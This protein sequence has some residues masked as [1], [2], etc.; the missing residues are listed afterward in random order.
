[1]RS[2]KECS[3]Y[4]N[5]ESSS[6]RNSGMLPNRSNDRFDNQKRDQLEIVDARRRPGERCGFL[7]AEEAVQV[8]LFL[9]LDD[10]SNRRSEQIRV[11]AHLAAIMGARV[12]W[13]VSLLNRC[14]AGF[15]DRPDQVQQALDIGV[16]LNCLSVH[17]HVD[18]IVRV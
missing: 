16:R 3:G 6:V 9:Y 17:A 18:Q 7:T 4:R 8:L 12:E 11:D 2:T 14:L 10:G 5:I 13:L 1:M 15:G